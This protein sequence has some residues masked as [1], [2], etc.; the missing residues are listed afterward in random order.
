MNGK[1]SRTICAFTAGFCIA[2]FAHEVS[3]K[4]GNLEALLRI[5]L[6]NY[7]R[8]ATSEEM[9]VFKEKFNDLAE[10][11]ESKTSINLYL[12]CK[13]LK[14]EIRTFYEKSYAYNIEDY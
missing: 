6:N 4:K 9:K 3:K 5:G 14:K 11:L 12:S 1:I 13:E 10:R 8:S 7:N 2:D